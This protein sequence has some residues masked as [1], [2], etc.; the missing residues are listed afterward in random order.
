MFL[1][2][3]G[4]GGGSRAYW[5][6]NKSPMVWPTW[7]FPSLTSSLLLC[8]FLSWIPYTLQPLNFLSASPCYPSFSFYAG[9]ALLHLLA[10]KLKRVVAEGLFA[11]CPVKVKILYFTTHWSA[12]RFQK[13]SELVLTFGNVEYTVNIFKELGLLV[14]S[15]LVHYKSFDTFTTS[16]NLLN[17]TFVL[18]YTERRCHF[19][20]QMFQ[21]I[22]HCLNACY[23]TTLCIFSVSGKAALWQGTR[24]T[25]TFVLATISF[26][27]LFTHNVRQ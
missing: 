11:S 14:G 27:S 19:W 4:G 9:P 20:K 2:H 7:S 24:S 3:R 13:G 8:Q 12:V 10:A 18:N 25:Q 17:H 6:P 1:H 15:H 22:F 16:V 5:Q 26:G 23:F 21:L